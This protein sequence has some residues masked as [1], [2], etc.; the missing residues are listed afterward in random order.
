MKRSARRI[1]PALEANLGLSR[2]RGHRDG[3][4]I[5]P[6]VRRLAIGAYGQTEH[7]DGLS[8]PGLLA[9]SPR[10]NNLADPQ[11]LTFAGPAIATIL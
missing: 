7:N 9:F 3:L 10:R 8:A 2:L 5:R 6:L 11:S 4:F 1:D